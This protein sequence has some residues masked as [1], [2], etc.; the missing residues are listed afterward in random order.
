MSLCIEAVVRGWNL[1]AWLEFGWLLNCLPYVKRM[2]VKLCAVCAAGGKAPACGPH[3][4][5]PCHHQF[6]YAPLPFLIIAA[7]MV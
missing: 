3:T 6:V 2:V 7:Y 5:L 1:C 4:Q